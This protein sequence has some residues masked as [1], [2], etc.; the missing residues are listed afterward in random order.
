MKE[1]DGRG[2][3]RQLWLKATSRLF[4]HESPLY[5]E[6]QRQRMVA[7]W[8]GLVLLSM[9]SIWVV[10]NVFLAAWPMILWHLAIIA[11][12]LVVLGL[13]NL[14]LPVLVAAHLFCLMML[15]TL[16]VSAY[17]SG[18]L[19]A[20]MLSL[21]A[22]APVAA[23]TAAGLSGVFWILPTVG[24]VS[25]LFL[26]HQRG[27]VFPF[28]TAPEQR[29]LDLALT[30]LTAA[31]T[32][33]LLIYYYESSRKRL[34]AE[35]VKALAETE[36]ISDQRNRLLQ[37]F[38]HE[39]RTPLHGILGLLGLMKDEGDPAVRRALGK[40]AREAGN[41]LLKTVSEVLEI[42][43]EGN[44]DERVFA[45]FIKRL[46]T[47][48]SLPAVQVAPGGPK[49]VM[50]VEDDAVSQMLAATLLERMGYQT[51]KVVDGSQALDVYR[52][53]RFGLVLMDCQLPGRD[54]LEITHLIREFEKSS[55][56]PPVP[57]VAVSAQASAEQKRACLK[58]GMNDFL[59]KPFGREE[60]ESLVRRWLG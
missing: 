9:L 56:R 12:C 25:L 50:I 59:P 29:P 42:S 44:S 1:T 37:L 52:H 33:T 23:V 14:G 38:G 26:Y 51:C 47:P 15:L 8:A 34:E 17:Y 10:I 11:A 3:I 53:G 31:A 5:D 24:L 13:M 54:G 43:R 60:L 39:I 55:G 28:L 4:P 36:R 45:P 16:L 58:A 7:H 41:L 6:I 35:L 40:Q 22:V 19:T 32:I 57:I 49:T 21:F 18:G 30:W 20:A 27:V 48:A 46:T 2:Q